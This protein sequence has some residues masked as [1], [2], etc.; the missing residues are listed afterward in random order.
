MISKLSSSALEAK[1]NA[2]KALPFG[3]DPEATQPTT[4]TQPTEGCAREQKPAQKES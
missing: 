2:A 1:D 3:P 4:T